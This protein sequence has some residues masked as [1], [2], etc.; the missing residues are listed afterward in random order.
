MSL[1]LAAGGNAITLNNIPV[2]F[3]LAIEKFKLPSTII[4]YLYTF[5]DVGFSCK[6]PNFCR[7]YS[8]LEIR[9]V[10]D[11]AVLSGC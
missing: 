3:L 9:R 2:V 1:G 5:V 7:R 6:V 4:A 10:G 8:K 11:E